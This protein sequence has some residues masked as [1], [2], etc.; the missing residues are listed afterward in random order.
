MS[1]KERDVFGLSVIFEEIVGGK[2]D[3][4]SDAGNSV[5]TASLTVGTTAAITT[6]GSIFKV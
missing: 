3:L 1:G 5:R 2:E 6:A 4:R